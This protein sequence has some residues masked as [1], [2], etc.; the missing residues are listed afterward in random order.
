VRYRRKVLHHM[1]QCK[2]CGAPLPKGARFCS[3]CGH[4][5]MA[6][7]DTAT[8]LSEEKI[9]TQPLLASNDENRTTPIPSGPATL[10][11]NK[12][13]SQ[14]TKQQSTSQPLG[15]FNLFASPI[16]PPKTPSGFL[17]DQTQKPTLDNNQDLQDNRAHQQA[18]FEHGTHQQPQVEHGTHQQPQVEH[19]THH[20][21]QIQHG[22]HHQPQ[23]QHGTHHQPQIQHGTHHQPQIQH[24]THHQ[25]QAVYRAHQQAHRIQPSQLAQHGKQVRR[26]QISKS[27]QPSYLTV[28][29]SS[30]AVIASLIV[31]VVLLLPFFSHAGATP[32]P[33]AVSMPETVDPGQAVTVKGR[34]FPPHSQA[35][36]TIDET[37]LTSNEPSTAQRP[38]VEANMSGAF[39]LLTTQQPVQQWYF[40]A[41]ITHLCAQGSNSAT[42]ARTE[43]LLLRILSY[44]HW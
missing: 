24:G 36:I 31:A 37:S 9:P 29:I 16:L 6:Q 41:R 5:L 40:D 28:S 3:A 1:A 13:P 10:L 8:L 20:Q 38:S 33:P 18:H 23:I 19:G 34:N 7:P 39:Q 17:L 21:P 22:T 26:L 43:E 25:P 2:N 30:V 32:P 12:A 4:S 14:Q 27:F 44:K 15:D 11:S 35:I 42:K